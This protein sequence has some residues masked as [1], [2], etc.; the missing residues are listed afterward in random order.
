MDRISS[1]RPAISVI[2]PA[3]NAGAFITEAIQSI[4]T[5]TFQDFE[6]LVGDDG[7]TDDTRQRIERFRDPRIRTIFSSKNRGKTATVQALY[8]L[9]TGEFVTIH[10]ADDISLPNRFQCQMNAFRRDPELMLCGVAFITVNKS[11]FVLE[12]VTMSDSYEVIKQDIFTSSQFHGPT[13]MIRKTVL[14][15][16]DEIYR[17]FFKDNYED[18]DL[19]FRIIQKYKGY[20]LVQ[21]LYVYRI[22][23]T[24]LCRKDVDIRNRNLYKIVSFLGK[25]RQETGSDALMRGQLEEVEIF[26]QEVTKQYV[27]DSALIYRE[28]SAY[29]FYWG[30]YRKS[31]GAAWRA[32]LT[33]PLKLVN[34]RLLFYLLRKILPKQIK[35]EVSKKH[36]SE[37]LL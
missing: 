33:A 5:Q 14:D 35:F 8:G 23:D 11:G 15:Q 21:P 19:A 28:A 34:L 18:T 20:N 26:Y 16:F 31:F 2:L 10:D 7:S 24:S 17:P 12:N 32:F 36:Y 29:Y 3:F 6:L 13:M 25:Q 4:L 22:L 30:L 27:L 37:T 1:S 9:A